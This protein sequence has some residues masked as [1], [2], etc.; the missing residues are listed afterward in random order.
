MLEHGAYC[1][2]L[3]RYYGTEQGI[4]ADQ[5]HRLA[6]AKSRDERSA[7]DAVLAEFFTLQDG[8]WINGRASR[9]VEKAQSKIKAAR[10]NG[11]L[12]GR[13]KRSQQE[14]TGLSLGSETGTHDQSKPNPLQTPD[15]RHQIPDTKTKTA[16]K[17]AAPGALVS[18]DDLVDAGVDRQH[19]DDW[20]LARKSKSLPLTPTAWAD[21]QAEA[22]KAGLTVPEAI[23]R[24]AANGWA[25]FKAA[26][27]ANAEAGRSG[28]G[29]PSYLAEKQAEAAKWARPSKPAFDYIEMEDANAPLGL[30]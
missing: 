27:L 2:L 26:W 25:G 8:I 24:A 19:A 10:G 11:K 4:P 30:R 18:A 12:G 3:D 17:R 9:E 14:P 23:G 29:P 7:V 5:A 6:R 21:T 20:L 28:S 22:I 15:T 1:L 13:P 16:R